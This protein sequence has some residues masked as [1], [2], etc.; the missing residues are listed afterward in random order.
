MMKMMLFILTLNVSDLIALLKIANMTNC[1]FMTFKF[2]VVNSRGIIV[3]NLMIFSAIMYPFG[4]NNGGSQFGGRYGI[5]RGPKIPSRLS[6][7][8]NQ[9]SRNNLSTSTLSI[10]TLSPEPSL[11]SGRNLPNA[12]GNNDSG[13]YV[14]N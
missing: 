11:P 10:N 4:N 5:N 14:F 7:R 3:F 6:L 2:F 13:N 8:R 1:L 9:V 12:V